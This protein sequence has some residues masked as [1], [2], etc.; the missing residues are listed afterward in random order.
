MSRVSVDV[1]AYDPRE[2]VR[3][4]Y[5]AID[6]GFDRLT[7]GQLPR[8]EDGMELVHTTRV[9]CRRPGYSARIEGLA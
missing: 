6:A 3:A 8:E 2:P 9:V 5:A 7:L 4:L 1:D